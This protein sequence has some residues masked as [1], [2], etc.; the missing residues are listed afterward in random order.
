MHMAQ[1]P[2]R[3]QYLRLDNVADVGDCAEFP[4]QC[5]FKD[6]YVNGISAAA[7]YVMRKERITSVSAPGNHTLTF[8]HTDTFSVGLGGQFNA[9][10]L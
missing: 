3:G 9:G 7:G 5:Y 6:F 10:Y 2:I 8:G 4:P 1:Y